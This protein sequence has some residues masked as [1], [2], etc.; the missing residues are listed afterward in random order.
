MDVKPGHQHQ[1][2]GTMLIQHEF[3]HLKSNGAKG[4]M[5]QCSKKN[6]RANSFYQKNGMNIIDESECYIRGIKL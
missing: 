5:L 6:E 4:V 1:G 2:I 3:Q